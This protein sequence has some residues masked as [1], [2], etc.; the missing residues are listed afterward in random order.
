MLDKIYGVIHCQHFYGTASVHPAAMFILQQQQQKTHTHTPLQ[1][2]FIY[3]EYL[4]P[5]ITSGPYMKWS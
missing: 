1:Q 5:Y 2:N 4:L 3:F